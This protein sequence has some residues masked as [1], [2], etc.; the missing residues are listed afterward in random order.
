[1]E[2]IKSILIINDEVDILSTLC[3][4][5]SEKALKFWMPWMALLG[6]SFLRLTTIYLILFYFIRHKHA[7][8][9]CWGIS[10]YK[11][12]IDTSLKDS[13]HTFV[14]GPSVIGNIPKPFEV[15]GLLEKINL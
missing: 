11:P 4:F 15:S 5:S 14:A 8:D 1:M 2:K 12:R 3:F 9:E 7:W 6:W 13:S 10:A